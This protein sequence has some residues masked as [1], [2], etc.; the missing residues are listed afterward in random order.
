MFLIKVSVQFSSVQFSHSV[1]SDSATPW[2]AACQ[3]SLFNTS[4]QSLPKLMLTKSGMP[5][6]HL[7]SVVPFSSGPQSFPAPGPFPM[8]QL[9]ASGGQSIFEYN[10]V[11][12]S[13]V[14]KSDSVI[15]IQT[16]VCI[17]IFFFRFFPIV[18]D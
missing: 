14:H 15:D 18:V 2:T 11:L 3:A 10:V 6:N 7:I 16:C 13:A 4:S 9:F 5:S 1:M 8:S 17:Y 12:V